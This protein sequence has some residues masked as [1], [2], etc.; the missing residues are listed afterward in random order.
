MDPVRQQFLNQI[1]DER[2]RQES[3]E[4]CTAEGDD[5][6]IKGELAWVAAAYAVVGTAEGQYVAENALWP[7]E[8]APE[9]F[10]PSSPERN[11]IKAGALILAELERLA[12]ARQVGGA[13]S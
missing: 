3:D 4:G 13:A 7:D 12:R 10:K 1:A 6:Y 2:A 5:S 9:L 8:W 11:L